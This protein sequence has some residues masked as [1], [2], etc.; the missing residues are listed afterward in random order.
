MDAYRVR[1]IRNILVYSIFLI[2]VDVMQ[3]LYVYRYKCKYDIEV[4]TEACLSLM[5]FL[6]F[7]GKL[8]MKY[9]SY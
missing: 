1:N 8:L 6:F 7:E 2:Y 9:L 4:K 5:S 3:S